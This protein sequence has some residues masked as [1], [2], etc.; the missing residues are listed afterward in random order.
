MGIG[1][2]LLFV[3]GSYDFLLF[4][5]FFSNEGGRGLGGG[6]ALF[7]CGGGRRRGTD[8][9]GWGALGGRLGV[10]GWI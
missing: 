10:W 4:S 2:G 3:G 1:V 8:G 5:Y 6:A 9:A 7:F